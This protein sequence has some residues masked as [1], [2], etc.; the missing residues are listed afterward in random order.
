MR[1]HWIIHGLIDRPMYI[2]EINRA[3]SGLQ[4]ET[5]FLLRF[6]SKADPGSNQDLKHHI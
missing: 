3:K 6:D 4:N 2:K 1:S 5:W